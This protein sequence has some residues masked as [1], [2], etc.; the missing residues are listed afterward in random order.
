MERVGVG[1]KMYGSEGPEAIPARPSG[2]RRLKP[3]RTLRNR[4]GKV[5]PNV[6]ELNRTYNLN[7]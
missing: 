1:N 7:S 2:K 3:N 4:E 6:I 5:R